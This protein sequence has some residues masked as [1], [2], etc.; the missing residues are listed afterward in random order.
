MLEKEAEQFH[1]TNSQEKYLNFRSVE[2]ENI[3]LKEM[4]RKLAPF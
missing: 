3:K 4:V 1:K 2:K